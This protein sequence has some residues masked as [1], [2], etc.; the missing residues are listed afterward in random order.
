M[1]TPEELK[2]EVFVK[3][4][5]H[6]KIEAFF[7]DSLEERMKIDD[8]WIE[9]PLVLILLDEEFFEH[10]AIHTLIKAMSNDEKTFNIL[11]RKLNPKDEYDKKIHDVLAELN[12]YY[13]LRKYSFDNIHALQEDNTQKM[14]D[15]AAVLRDERFVFEVKNMRAPIEVCDL[16]LVK[17]EARANRFPEI[18]KDIGIFFTPSQK[19]LEVELNRQETEISTKKVE[20]WLEQTFTKI[21]Y[22]EVPASGR[23]EPFNLVSQ[24]L[25]IECNLKRRKDLGACCGLKRGVMVSDPDYQQS[26]LTPFSK[27][28]R[29]ITCNASLQLLEYDENNVHQKYVLVNWQKSSKLEGLVWRG[30]ENDVHKIVKSI[31]LEVKNRS[32][33]LFI[34]FLNFDSLP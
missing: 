1:K 7:K 3:L 18:Y 31:D 20:D 22:A 9:N 5:Q 33:D 24:G 27:K 2:K 12:A 34:K 28:V 14:P 15:F 21:E 11:K 13:H 17:A 8:G 10:S 4:S 6:P 23:L 19:W 25:T 16:L 29:R 30:F 26:V 32:N